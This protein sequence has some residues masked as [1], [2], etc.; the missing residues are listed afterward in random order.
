MTTALNQQLP[1]APDRMVIMGVAGSGKSSVGE[2]LAARI[3]ALYIDGDALHPP[4]N[5]E[6]MSSGIALTDE[7]RLPW[8]REIGRRLGEDS[9][10]MIVGCSALKRA[11]RDAIYREAGRPV[12]F[13][14]LAGTPQIIAERMR[15]R[16]GH[17]M[18]VSLLNSQFAALEEPHPDENA[19]RIDIDQPFD[20]LVRTAVTLLGVTRAEGEV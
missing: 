6:K 19:I 8:L 16:A 14:Y 11:Y 9:G 18:P 7:D 13:V 4:A 20:D 5:I 17:F 15:K 2:A 12:T 10:T 1:S 3:G